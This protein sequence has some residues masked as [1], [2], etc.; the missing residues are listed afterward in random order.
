MAGSM[1]LVERFTA[2]AG[3]AIP[4]EHPKTK[5]L[6]KTTRTSLALSWDW[7][8]P[9]GMEREVLRRLNQEQGA[10]LIREHW[11]NTPMPYLGGRTPFRP[12]RRATPSSRSAPRSSSWNCTE[13]WRDQVD[14]ASLRA[15]LNIPPEPAIDPETVK[16]GTLHLARLNLVPVER[17]DD[18][19]WPD[20]YRRARSVGQIDVLE[21][22][23]ATWSTARGLGDG[24]YR[25][26]GDLLRPGHAAAGPAGSRGVR[27]DPPGPAGRPAAIRPETPRVGLLEVRI[28][29]RSEAP[30]V[31]V[32]ELAVVLERYQ[33]DPAA[34][35]AIMFTL[36]EMGLIEMQPNPDRPDDILVD[37]RAAASVDGRIRPEGHHGVGTAR[38]LGDQ[39]GD[40]D[41]G[42]RDRRRR[43]PLDS[44]VRDRTDDLRR[45]RKVQAHLSRAVTHRIRD[46]GGRSPGRGR[47]RPHDPGQAPRRSRHLR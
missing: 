5:V 44:R 12:R 9:E 32:P 11:P 20:L 4:P 42:L 30:E 24:P 25:P 38:C 13:S 43:R 8:I 34:S 17:L 35:Q 18:E 47:V 1:A 6:D 16:I 7:L 14:F 23:R 37:T 31:W 10:R 19:R 27:L 21:A 29:A 2:L 41:P 33:D 39:G 46:P 15:S 28:K 36:L 3:Q 45:R 22:P 26:D 40:L